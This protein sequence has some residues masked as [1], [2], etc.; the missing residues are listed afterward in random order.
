MTFRALALSALLLSGTAAAQQE[1]L[2]TGSRSTVTIAVRKDGAPFVWKDPKSN[3]FAGF[4]WDLCTEAATRAGW[5]IAARA[6]DASDRPPFLDGQS[7]EYDLLCDPT[8]INIARL[9][10][11]ADNDLSFSPIV[12][13]ANGVQIHATE[14]RETGAG[15]GTITG[16]AAGER[17]AACEVALDGN[18]TRA[19]APN[20]PPAPQG[21][22]ERPL[23]E[24]LTAW[25]GALDEKIWL[26]Y[27]APSDAAAPEEQQARYT[28][29]G[30]VEGS[31]SA[32]IVARQAHASEEG[33]WICG[34]EYPSHQGAARALCEGEIMRYFG[35]LELAR[36]ALRSLEKPCAFEVVADAPRSYEPYAFVTS[37]AN[38]ADFP[39]RFA[40]EIYGMFSDGTVERLFA[41]HFPENDKSGFLSTLF[42]INAVPEGPRVADT[43]VQAALPDAP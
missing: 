17:V 32:E 36:A 2:D 9:R 22:D 40:L 4:F 6:I 38:F 30:F 37:G 24:R 25:F 10:A 41:G 19:E 42:R 12:F 8:T 31:T 7:T 29:Y 27:P 18:N 3:Q 35:D 20:P 16:E 15:A 33:D 11:F 43:D 26:R 5:S 28:I 23:G 34:R 13:L 21:P 39:E 14:R 1:A